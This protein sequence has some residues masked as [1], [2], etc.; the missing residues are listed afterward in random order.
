MLLK[1]KRTKIIYI[2]TF[3]MVIQ[4]QLRAIECF[5]KDAVLGTKLQSDTM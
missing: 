3:W 4:L 1:K 2:F 5:G